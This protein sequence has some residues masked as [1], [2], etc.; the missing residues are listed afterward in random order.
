MNQVA[1]NMSYSLNKFLENNK[2]YNYKITSNA[3]FIDNDIE[4]INKIDGVDYAEAVY[5][6]DFIGEINNADRR[7]IRA[8][9]LT[10]DN[11]NL[12]QL[13]DG[14]M[15]EKSNEC[16]VLESNDP[17]KV[18][19][20]GEKI[21]SNK[22]AKS[23]T[24]FTEEEFEVVG[25]INSSTY[26]YFSIIGSTPLESGRLENVIYTTKDAYSQSAYTTVYIKGSNDNLQAYLD[27][28]AETRI[29]EIPNGIIDK[30]NYYT[31]AQE[32]NDGINCYIDDV[33]RI[34]NLSLYF[35]IV[36]FLVAVIV[37]ITIIFRKVNEDKFDIGIAKSLGISNIIILFQYLFFS[38]F[39]CVIGCIIGIFF[40]GTLVPYI[41]IVIYQKM[42]YLEIAN[43]QI[44]PDVI[45][46][47]FVVSVL[48]V[49]IATFF[50][51]WK[52]IKM[53]EKQLLIKTVS[54]RTSKIRISNNIPTLWIATIRSAL[55][56][57]AR[58]IMSVINIALCMTICLCSIHLYSATS[59][60]VNKQIEDI[61]QDEYEAYINENYENAKKVFNEANNVKFYSPSAEKP[62][63]FKV[64][65]GRTSMLYITCP[66]N[67]E[68]FSKF[69]HLIDSNSGE[70]VEPNDD[71]VVITKRA[72]EVC[73]VNVGDYIEIKTDTVNPTE[74]QK[75]KISHIVDNYIHN[76]AY[77]TKSKYKEIVGKDYSPNV[78]S[79]ALDNYNDLSL[80]NNQLYK[81][82]EVSF[83]KNYHDTLINYTKIADSSVYL[84][85]VLCV[86]S[87]FLAFIVLYSLTVISLSERSNEIAI[88]KM[89]GFKPRKVNLYVHRDTLFYSI[90][91]IILGLIFGCMFATLV[92]MSIEGISIMFYRK[93]TIEVYVC[94]ICLVL[95]FVLLFVFI[96]SKF[97][98]RINCNEIL[99]GNE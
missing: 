51:A 45:C 66:E 86:F 75:I 26:I 97:T 81:T 95:A 27:Q 25:K 3:G 29:Q 13:T 19:N 21:V 77:V 89:L 69:R 18:I 36:F 59:N 37:I 85:I 43:I 33:N 28:R 80:F 74:Y 61:A 53:P 34:A 58:F 4:N 22:Q 39:A 98:N 10:S 91:G 65:D 24:S 96:L 88:I 11:I 48:F 46:L 47:T 42:Y 76:Y 49:L 38:L 31:F 35:P 15:P 17:S 73:R 2:T 50:A 56:H 78:I 41:F 90:I 9:S 71:G 8:E 12:L 64:P 14:R 87:A 62:A 23:S 54:K 82:G 94:S 63:S 83:I 72:A 5:N 44:M 84:S 40:I 68:D 55:C 7:V 1:Y 20:I 32:K 16:V 79:A 52:T 6:I 67:Y 99:T 70:I 30:V 92:S 57:P 93:V 60:M